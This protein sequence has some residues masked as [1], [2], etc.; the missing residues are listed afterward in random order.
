MQ[1]TKIT[2]TLY[3]GI[4][5]TG[6]KSILR[7]KQCFIDA[8]GEI[9]SMIGFLAIDSAPDPKNE[10]VTTNR[11]KIVKLDPNEYLVCTVQNA[12]DIF[13]K[14][15]NEFTWVPPLNVRYLK[16]IHGTGAG[17]IR[18]NG[19]FIAQ[20]NAKAIMDTINAKV[21]AINSPLDV[22]SPYEIDLDDNGMVYP[23]LINIVGSLSGGTGSGMMIDTIAL[24]SKALRDNGAKY[25]I[26][27]WII[28]PDIFRQNIPGVGSIDVKHN[29]YGALAELD[30]LF[31]LDPT[32]KKPLDFVFAK[33]L[34]LDEGIDYAYVINNT[35]KMGITFQNISDVTD[36]V[37]RSMFLPSN[38]FNGAINTPMDDIVTKKQSF[39]IE[40]KQA[41]AASIGSAELIYD[42]QAVGN[43]IARSIICDLCDELQKN[44][45]STIDAQRA[46]QTWMSSQTVQIQEDQAD[47][48]IDSLLSA[49]PQ[50]SNSY[51]VDEKTDETLVNSY[52]DNATSAQYITAD[53]EEKFNNK[54][55]IVKSLL[56][57][58]IKSKINAQ[59]GV[60]DVESFLVGLTNCIDICQGQMQSEKAEFDNQL[61][62]PINWKAMLHSILVTGP[63]KIFK[64]AYDKDSAQMVSQEILNRIILKREFI[65]RNWA[66]QFY[67]DF[68]KYINEQLRNI[69]TLKNNLAQ[70]SEKNRKEILMIQNQ[71]S[72]T[73][74]F[75]VFLHKEAVYNYTR[76]TINKVFTGYS[77]T[78]NIYNLLTAS[79]TDIERSFMDYA[80]TDSD[81]MA[82]V[83][84]TIDDVLD[85]MNDELAM[86]YL[87]KVKQM[88]APMW[89]VNDRGYRK[90]KQELYKDTIIGCK[91]GGDGK[92]AISRNA[93]YSGIFTESD[94]KPYY[95]TTRQTDR[96]LILVIESCAPIYAVNNVPSYENESKERQD[97]VSCYL[98]ES[99]HNRI[100]SEN[101]SIWPQMEQPKVVDYWVQ[102]FIFKFIQFNQSTNTYQIFSL[103]YGNPI[104]GYMFD[105]GVDRVVAFDTF[106]T[107]GLDSEV[108]DKISDLMREKGD[109]YVMNTLKKVHD[110]GNYY[111]DFASL[112]PL[113]KTAIDNSDPHYKA[114]NDLIDKEINYITKSL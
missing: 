80:K 12:L 53:I 37:G 29:T 23:T 36:S 71:A 19:R 103:K 55:A 81:V 89:G 50:G 17:A 66:M 108:H 88:A 112:N 72:S 67:T 47:Q 22:N 87:N 11:G 13:T 61:K 7:T 38:G 6:V 57:G 8:Y 9:P 76:P 107:M 33:I 43:V 52:I 78:N 34:T 28:L 62:N 45:F 31:H 44:N 102:A 63:A 98:D 75:Q 18:S 32:N 15:P 54:I 110:D 10:S 4:G 113:E 5:G 40:H 104:K 25:R 51:V 84:V 60:G 79:L 97:S 106:R 93:K 49:T 14:M 111:P 68:Q 64:G 20:Y 41:W 85:K 105:L 2:K 26:I 74:K 56:D 91:D 82:A 69:K 70:L 35:N 48:L 1:K 21:A 24:V 114:L 59:T 27:P 101:F 109:P 96:F 94:N 90:Q 86:T 58:E 99:W 39:D 73:S 65:R 77:T 3:I 42:N 83:N 30:Y 100:A 46:A 16:T 92:N 95:C